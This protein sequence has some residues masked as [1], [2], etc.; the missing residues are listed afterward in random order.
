[1][2]VEVKVCFILIEVKDNNVCIYFGVEL[3]NS[4]K[5]EVVVI[6][7]KIVCLGFKISKWFEFFVFDNEFVFDFIFLFK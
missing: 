7:V 4:V 6:E 3:L 2:G 1:M 5:V